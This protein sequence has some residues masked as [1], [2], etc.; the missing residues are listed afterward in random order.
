MKFKMSEVDLAKMVV[1]HLVDWGWEVYQEV[2]GNGTG[3]RC[4]IVGKRGKVLWAIECKMSFGFPVIEQAAKWRFRAHYV[5]IAIPSPRSRENFGWKV[6]RDYGIGML[7]C[8]HRDITEEIRPR[9]HRKIR[10][11]EVFEEQKTF[12]DAGSP[13]GGHWT[14]FKCTVRNL[15]AEVNRCPGIEFNQLIKGLDHHYHTFG[16]AKSCLRGFIGTVIPELRAEMV[17]RK[18]C[19]FPAEVK[20]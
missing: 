18:L 2:D 16:T 15:V 12:C 1:S 6:C 9:L 3:G 5:S 19:V 20:Q 13:C 10:P 17:G 8:R 11:L 4:D 7:T 14:R